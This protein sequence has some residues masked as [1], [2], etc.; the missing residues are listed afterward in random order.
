[1]RWSAPITPAL[2]GA[3]SSTSCGRRTLG[4]GLEGAF[5]PRASDSR[6]L[7]AVVT[8]SGTGLLRTESAGSRRRRSAGAPARNAYGDGRPL[9]TRKRRSA[10][11][12]RRP[13]RRARRRPSRRRSSVRPARHFAA[14]RRR[15]PRRAPRRCRPARTAASPER[16]RARVGARRGRR[17]TTIGTS[18]PISVQRAR[19][20]R[21]P[22]ARLPARETATLGSGPAGREVL[23]AGRGAR[24]PARA[25]SWGTGGGW[26][27]LRAK[28][29]PPSRAQA[30]ASDGRSSA[31]ARIHARHARVDGER[32]RALPQERRPCRTSSSSAVR[33]HPGRGVAGRRC[34]PVVRVGARGGSLEQERRVHPD[35]DGAA[36]AQRGPRGIRVVPEPAPRAARARASFRGGTSRERRGAGRRQAF[37]GSRGRVRGASRL[38]PAPQAGSRRGG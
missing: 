34:G 1:M 7:L 22:A 4:S 36:R 30:D 14:R 20:R 37:A 16:E 26:A 2:I 5:N 31:F 19:P 28:P 23:V 10:A 3:A 12:R 35:A 21:A 29:G 11:S 17:R 18:S 33:R 27:P 32:P 9:A 25:S 6:A 13:A 8:G 15:R 38:V 24:T